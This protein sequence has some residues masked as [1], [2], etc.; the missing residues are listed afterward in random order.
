M[1]IYYYANQVY[2]LSFAKLVYKELGGIFV[3]SR[4]NRKL[5][6]IWYLRASQRNNT[7][8]KIFNKIPVGYSDHA[9]GHVVPL[10]A[11]ALGGCVIEKHMTDDQSGPGPDHRISLEVEEFRRMVEDVR[12]LE[13]A[14]GHPTK[15]VAP[16]ERNTVILQ[17]RSLW[18]ARDIPKGAVLAR[19]MFD[20]LRPQKGIHPNDLDKVLGLRLTRDIQAGH[21]L[22][23][24]HFK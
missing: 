23:W 10:G 12:N 14:L 9:P 24:E 13:M 21:P 6:L 4:L 22:T 1:N 17:R 11:V 16:A 18:A 2:Q 8:N 7:I 19:E 3:V 20:I 5:R 15:Q